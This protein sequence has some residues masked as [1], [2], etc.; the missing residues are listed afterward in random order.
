MRKPKTALGKRRQNLAKAS[1]RSPAAGSMAGKIYSGRPAA[2][3]GT[4]CGRGT[5]G[6]TTVLLAFSV[7]RGSHGLCIYIL[8]GLGYSSRAPRLIG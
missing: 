7:E 6:E 3:S 2:L 4:S 5:G 1:A 8:L